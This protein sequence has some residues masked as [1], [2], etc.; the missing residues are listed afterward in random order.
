MLGWRWTALS[1]RL[2]RLLPYSQVHKADEV[3]APGALDVGPVGRSRSQVGVARHGRE[4][5]GNILAEST[6][7]GGAGG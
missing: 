5:I 1:L 7:F 3:R 4:R 6:A 2:R